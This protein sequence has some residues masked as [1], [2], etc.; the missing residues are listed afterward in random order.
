MATLTGAVQ[1][2]LLDGFAPISDTG[3]V[4][5]YDVGG[6]KYEFIDN[7]SNTSGT[8]YV[9]VADGVSRVFLK[10]AEGASIIVGDDNTYV[11]SD[12]VSVGN[13]IIAGHGNNVIALSDGN[14][15]VRVGSGNNQIETGNGDDSVT[16]GNGNNIIVTGDGN[17]VVIVG[18]G[19]NVIDTGSGNDVIKVTGNGAGANHIDAGAGNDVIVLAVGAGVDTIV[20]GH[21]GDV[22]QVKNFDA[23]GNE[24]KIAKAPTDIVG[25]VGANITITS[26]PNGT[27]VTFADGSKIM[28]IGVA[29]TDVDANDFVNS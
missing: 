24:D 28:L 11:N 23:A 22:D 21:A 2:A 15:A 25:A 18:N 27:V 8:P 9:V 7:F 29:S 20:K 13:K 5:I 14:D 10:D 1:L 16:A 26:D 6:S 19:N 4:R 3:G 12:P 17:D